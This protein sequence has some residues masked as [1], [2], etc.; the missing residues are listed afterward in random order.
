MK[1]KKGTS[2][3]TILF[4]IL[5]IIMT[6][7]GFFLFYAEEVSKAQNP[8][9]TNLNKTNE[10]LMNITRDI[11]T[12]VQ[13]VKD[14][15]FEVTESTGVI[16]AGITTV[17][18]FTAILKLLGQTLNFGFNIISVMLLTIGFLFLVGRSHYSL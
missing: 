17:K 12:T 5:V 2:I 18:G 7:S 9:D 16:S 14:R 8:I 13:D 3:L 1:G 15:T 11:N 4:A 10:I 6:F